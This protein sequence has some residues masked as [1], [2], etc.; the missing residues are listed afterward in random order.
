MPAY[1]NYRLKWNVIIGASKTVTPKLRFGRQRD[2]CCTVAVRM[3]LVSA[4]GGNRDA[5]DRDD[6]STITQAVGRRDSNVALER[7]EKRTVARLFNLWISHA[8]QKIGFVRSDANHYLPAVF[9]P[10]AYTRR[11]EDHHHGVRLPVSF[12]T[13]PDG[14]DVRYYFR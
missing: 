5:S 14:I 13:P 12:V 7:Q 10:S 8:G 6:V 4:P 3:N 1:L 9:D 2:C 11:Q